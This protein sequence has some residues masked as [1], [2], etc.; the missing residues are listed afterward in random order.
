MNRVFKNKHSLHILLSIIITIP[1]I[2]RWITCLPFSGKLPLINNGDHLSFLGRYFYFLNSK[3]NFPLGRIDNLSIPFVDSNISR[4]GLPFF[5]FPLK[6]L[7]LLDINIQNFNFFAFSEFFGFFVTAYLA[8]E[9]FNSFKIES[10]IYKFLGVFLICYAPFFLFR[11]S[12]MYGISFVFL[13]TPLYLLW[14]LTRLKL[15]NYDLSLKKISLYTLV[16]IISILI[17]NYVLISITLSG[18]FI[19]LIKI[20]LYLINP[21]KINLASAKEEFLL[22]SCSL[23]FSFLFINLLGGQK[24]E[25]PHP[26]IT[27]LT[28]RY[29]PNGRGG[30]YGGGIHLADLLSPITPQGVLKYP[31]GGEEALISKLGFPISTDRWRNG[32]SDGFAFIGSISTFLLLLVLLHFMY[33]KLPQLNYNR[34]NLISLLKKESFL[35]VLSCLFIFLVSMG[36]ILHIN[37]IRYYDVITPA[38][39]INL[40]YPKMLIVRSLGRLATQFSLMLIIFLI[41]YIYKNLKI[42]NNK[43]TLVIALICCALQ[44]Y[45]SNVFLKAPTAAENELFNLYTQD[46]TKKIERFF[47]SK[48]LLI[49]SSFLRENV[50]WGKCIYSLGLK[51]DLKLTGPTVGMGPTIPQMKIYNRDKRMA[52]SLNFEGLSKNYHNFVIALNKNYIDKAILKKNYQTLYLDKCEILLV[53]NN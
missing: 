9:I 7:H 50:K 8:F 20:I 22:F 14:I 2:K 43:I 15:S 10:I 16:F 45:E 46:E 41:V 48:N 21:A 42:K 44:F 3:A 35:I 5:T 24:I 34:K 51:N 52:Q 31:K 1:F 6:A 47:E 13:A 32:Q 12:Y 28:D 37:G 11:S 17:N 38:I 4:G 26:E 33:K 27:V 25:R 53:K 49:L 36:Y 30:G 18:A 40:A 39:I 23:I 29:N 19:L